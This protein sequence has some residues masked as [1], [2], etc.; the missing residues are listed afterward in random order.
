M[1]DLTI[2]MVLLSLLRS[3][4]KPSGNVALPFAMQ[5]FQQEWMKKLGKQINE[6]ISKQQLTKSNQDTGSI[7]TWEK[8]SNLGSAIYISASSTA[9]SSN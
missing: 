7:V 3:P 5:L 1:D 2:D 9:T 8:H 4:S 6:E